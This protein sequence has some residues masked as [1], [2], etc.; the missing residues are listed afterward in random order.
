MLDSLRN[1]VVMYAR[2]LAVAG[3]V[4]TAVFDFRMR[5]FLKESPCLFC[6]GCEF[7]RDGRCDHTVAHRYGCFEAER[8]NGLYIYYCPMSL[9]FMATLIYEEQQAVYAIITGPAVMGEMEDVLVEN[10]DCMA[11]SIAALPQRTAAESTSMA[12]VQR[13]VSMFLSGRGIETEDFK[14][15]TQAQLLNTLYDVTSEMRSHNGARY[16][17]EMEQR[18]QRMI[19]QGDKQGAQEMINQLLGSLY[20]HSGGDLAIIKQR[21]R[22]LVVLFSR[23]SMDGG[24][25]V[26]QI[27]GH[28]S[29]YL[30][31]I[32]KFSSLDELSIFLTSIFY[33]F[34]GYVFDFG[35]FEHSDIL[36]KTI[37]FVRENYAD[38]ITLEDA[39][40]HV[41][42]SRSYLSTI[43]KEEMGSSFTD[44]VN[45]LRVQK[46]MELLLNPALSL[47]E[48]ADLVG[49]ND[50]SYYTKVF[51]RATGV[52]PGQYRK[53]RGK[54]S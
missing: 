2:H 43:F 46:S 13:A 15:R 53:K 27:F 8:W 5:D 1:S 3:A 6:P 26:L 44:Y 38:K 49:Y 45:G 32:D 7:N 11:R 20:F 18:L 24:A 23:A 4:P 10:G 19:T 17:L 40:A 30:A 31:E 28:N 47:A 35:R 22:E 16:P 14:G 52:S 42:L 39:A 34:V 9:A 36:H 25:D 50:Q 21:A 37:G 29:D 12:Q 33:R 54:I 51:A 41:G 48:I